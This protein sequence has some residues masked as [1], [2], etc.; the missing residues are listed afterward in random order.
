ME[1]RNKKRDSMPPPDATPEEIGEFWDTH[2]LADY[3]DET[4]EVEFQVDL[5]SNQNQTQPGETK[6]DLPSTAEDA[7]NTTLDVVTD[8]ALDAAIPAPIRRNALK[9][10]DRLCS[11]LIDVPIGALERRSTEKRAESEA[12]IKIREE[13]TAQIVQQ[14]QVNPEYALKAGHKFAEKIIREQL[15]LDKI[16]AIAANELKNEQSDTSINQETSEPN[17]EQTADS[18]NQ[19]A[20]SGEGK[21]IDD[22]WINGFETEARQK[23]TEEMQLRFGRI[24]AGEIRQPCSYSIKSVKT[25]GELDQNTANLFKKFC[26]ACVIVGVLGIPNSEQVFD[27]R[28]LSLGGSLG[29]NALSKYGLGLDQLNIL[30]EYSLITSGDISLHDYNLVSLYDYNLCIVYEDNPVRLPFQHQGKS[31]ALLPLPDWDHKPKFLVSGVALS[32]VGRELFRI[33]DQDPMPEYTE[34][35]EKFFAEQKLQMVEVTRR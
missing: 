28:V 26:S 19:E 16:S 24:L 33:V 20:D 23:S 27:A 3:W 18:P 34:D 14:I 10:F 1:K 13:I 29:S 8:L 17:K 35:L 32:R 7:S 6:P 9:A 2:S 11:V 21:V 30:N 12:R 15:N 31:W 22:D 25:L 5:K 4:D